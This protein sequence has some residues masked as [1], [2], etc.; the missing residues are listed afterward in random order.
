MGGARLS[1][2][3]TT[4][5]ASRAAGGLFTSVRRSAQALAGLAHEV[6]VYTLRDVHAQEDMAAWA[7]LRPRLFDSLG[8]AGLGIAPA[9]PAALV[10][11]GHSLLHQHG[12][13]QYLSVASMA[14]RRRTGRP[15][16]I[17][18]RGMLDPWA[19]R[20]SQLK[21]RVAAGLFE[22]ANLNA[23]SC[24]HALNASEASA[25]R[26]FGLTNPVAV[27]PNAVDLPSAAEI[28]A[29]A[30]PPW[31]RDG[32]AGLLFLGRIHPK[33]GLS[34]SL[35]AWARLKGEAPA[36]TARWRLVVA[37]WDDGGHLAPLVAEARGL[38]LAEDDAVFPGPLFGADKVAALAH[39]RAFL[40]AS[41][42]EGLPMAVLEAWAFGLPAFMSQACNL[43]EGFA[44]G[45]AVLAP[46]EPEALAAAFAAHLGRTDLADMGERGRRLVLER[47]T[48]E[49]AAR[50]FEALYRWLISRGSCEA[51]PFVQFAELDSRRARA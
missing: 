47:F 39:A 34:E 20:N 3:M 32:R 31:A 16:L 27:I 6:A 48:W 7:P 21:K 40:L 14:W 29:A 43:P 42:S 13:W 26:A 36:L 11:G 30:P 17:S 10:A 35:R 44:H 50:D 49:H 38:G 22:R 46:P 24:L 12:L 9:M 19:L 4:G 8:P 23:A 25:M 5:S 41:H 51:P 1:V 2:A 45:A 18:P 15:S 28:A 37:G 33:K